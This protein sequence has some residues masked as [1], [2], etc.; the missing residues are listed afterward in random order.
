MGV[1]V[2]Q[3]GVRT[4]WARSRLPP[5]HRPRAAHAIGPAAPY[6]RLC[7]NRS[8]GRESGWAVLV[9]PNPVDAPANVLPWRDRSS[10]APTSLADG[11]RRIAVQRYRGRIFH[12]E[13]DRAG[14]CYGKPNAPRAEMFQMRLTHPL[15]DLYRPHLAPQATSTS[16]APRRE[17][18][19]FREG[20][21]AALDSRGKV[22]EH[23]DPNY[24]TRSSED[25]R[26]GAND[27]GSGQP[28]EQ[29]R[30]QQVRTCEV[31]AS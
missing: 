22:V 20:D 21:G 12:A 3:R 5:L 9:H 6:G 19:R 29:T 2:D 25:Q 31:L 24:P 30:P 15:A 27:H 16:T 23:R 7:V 4:C 18:A 8:R 11:T 28:T 13:S 10:A 17:M 26:N 1:L 14:G